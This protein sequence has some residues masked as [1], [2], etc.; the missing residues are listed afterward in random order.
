MARIVI[1]TSDQHLDSAP[2]GV[3]DA[4][5]KFFKS[6]L[7]RD[8]VQCIVTVGD[9]WSMAIDKT[10]DDVIKNAHCAAVRD[11]LRQFADSR[12]LYLVD[13][14]HDPYSTMPKPE[15]AKF[16]Q[17]L[18]I[19]KAIYAG[20]TLN[21]RFAGLPTTYFMHG[22]QFDPSNDFWKGLTGTLKGILG[23]KAALALINWAIGIYLKGKRAPTPT[24]V[25]KQDKDSYA[26]LV[27]YMH[28]EMWKW[29][30]GKKNGYDVCVM[31]H[32]HFDEIR[33]KELANKTYVNCGA[34]DGLGNSYVEIGAD[35][36]RL[37]EW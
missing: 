23:T 14:N 7:K 20:P 28:N 34:F 1:A 11:V 26:L 35:G 29:T 36:P 33:H 6:L 5:L 4:Q 8:D 13:G 2:A 25:R 19:P 18:N 22:H 17:W 9:L 30:L 21:K 31:G 37:V 12:P 3:R 32:T 27:E 16:K 24:E 10:V 15:L